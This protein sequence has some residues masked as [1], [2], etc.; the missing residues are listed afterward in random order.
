MK[1]AILTSVAGNGGSAATAYHNA[2]VLREAGEDAVLFA[3]G[4]YWPE[5]GEK[6]GVPVQGDLELRR[7]F[8][9][10][11]F[12]GDFRRLRRFIKKE[13]ADAV[14]VQ[15]SPEQ[16]LAFF[17]LKTISRKIAFV[18]LRGV[19]FPIRPSL[20][21]RWIHNAADLVLCSASLIAGGFRALPGFR[22]DRLRTLLEGVDTERF[23]PPG[24]EE[25]GAARE[26]FGLAPEALYIGTAGRPA[27]VKGHDVLVRAF[28]QA[29]GQV[30]PGEREVRLAI[31]SDESRRGPGSYNDLEKLCDELGIW[32]R[33]DLKPGYLEDMR[34]VY[35][36][37]DV[38]VLPS[39]GSEGSSRAALEARASGLP[40]IASSVGVLP[41]LID[42]GVN[43]KLVPPGDV[44]VLAGELKRLIEEWPTARMWG[45]AARKTSEEHFREQDYAKKLVSM[46]REAVG[47]PADDASSK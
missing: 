35:R 30:K 45:E 17:V 24:D 9:P 10:F 28:A 42:D 37:L 18:R 6:E 13:Q 26:R 7:G 14:I 20:F 1:I 36:A 33:V 41:D 25:R 8:R 11:S 3:P 22:Q 39:R 46:L 44:S 23:V 47:S 27:P 19:V 31:F 12:F 15:K 2:K 29:H 5:R 32:D 43:G 21:N 40:L 4:T 16:W 34:D 38:Y